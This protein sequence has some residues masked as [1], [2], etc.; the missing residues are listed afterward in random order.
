MGNRVTCTDAALIEAAK[1]ALIE[2]QMIVHE[3]G[4]DE[5]RFMER[6]KAVR[7]LADALP[8]DVVEEAVW[9]AQSNALASEHP[10]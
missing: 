8:E 1:L 3:P 7:V 9:A 10:Q 4:Y 2:L 6:M 5:R